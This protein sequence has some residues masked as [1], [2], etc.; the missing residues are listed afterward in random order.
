MNIVLETIKTRRSCRKYK[1]EPIS[2]EKMIRIIDAGLQAP[3]GGSFQSCHFT[4][5]Q[6]KSIIEQINHEIYMTFS[7]SNNPFLIQVSKRENKDFFYGA[8]MIVIVSGDS[9][10]I[11]PQDDMAVASQNMMLAAESIGI[12]SCW[13]GFG[14]ALSFTGNFEKYSKLL[15][16]PE[17]HV[18]HHA[19]VFGYREGNDPNPINIKENRVNIIN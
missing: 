14:G 17:N 13:I 3:S 2:E 15:E 19:V 8:P 11:T 10:A 5:L 9:A 7:S 12:S 6:N 18:P 16:L 4:V 1:S